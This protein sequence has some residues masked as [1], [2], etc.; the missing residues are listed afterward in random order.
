MQWEFIKYFFIRMKYHF[1]KVA[2]DRCIKGWKFPEGDFG[3]EYGSGYPN[4]KLHRIVGKR[5]CKVFGYGTLFSPLAAVRLCNNSY[6]LLQLPPPIWSL[7][8]NINVS[9]LSVTDVRKIS[10]N[11]KYMFTYIVVRC[12]I[13]YHLY[14]LKIVKNTHG[15]VF[16]LVKL[17]TEAC[18]FTKSNTPPWVFFMFFKLYNWYQIAQSTTYIYRI[19]F[20]VFNATAILTFKGTFK[21]IGYNFMNK[22]RKHRFQWFWLKAYRFLWMMDVKVTLHLTSHL[23]S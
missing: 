9:K 20:T 7:K 13:W 22:K 4:G 16:L 5:Y 12:A 10:V 3:I 15:G 18:I 6:S 17:Q 23:M 14:S 19:P 1:L 2:R 21:E 8:V 11:L